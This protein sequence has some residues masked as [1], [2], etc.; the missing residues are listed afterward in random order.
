[1]TRFTG[2]LRIACSVAMAQLLL[3]ACSSM[4][5]SKKE[6]DGT[7]RKEPELRQMYTLEVRAP[8]AQKS[9]LTSFL[10]LAR[11]Q[12]GPEADRIS[13]E[14][15]DRLVAG[16]PAQARSLV[17]TQGYFNSQ[18]TA[19]REG[20][21]RDGLPLVIVELT[22]GPRTTVESVELETSGHLEKAASARDAK[23]IELTAEVRAKWPL[24]SGEAFTQSEWDGAKNAALGVLRTDGYPAASWA[25]TSARIDADSN[26]ARLYG[27]ADS[28]PLF[29][30]GDVL[31]TGLE[32]YDP[33]AVRNL[34][35]F[36]GG[37]R[38]SEKAMLDTQDRLQRSGLFEGAVV[39]I[40][41]D[42]S[43][44][45]AVP[46]TVKVREAPLQQATVGIGFAD[47]TGERVTLEHTHRRVFG[48]KFFGTN[49]VAKNKLDLGR[50]QQSWQGDFSSHPLEGGWRNILGA[51][52]RRETAK[53]TTVSSQRL[54][55][56]RAVETERIDRLVYL[57]LQQAKTTSSALTESNRALS[58]NYNWI[59][60]DIDNNLLPTLGWA[61]NLESAVGYSW[62]DTSDSGAFG[63]LKAR[64]T[65]FRPLGSTWFGNVRLEI[66]QVF[67]NSAVGIPDTLLFRAGGD[68]SVRGYAY[69]S[70]GP[71]LTGVV[72]SG[73][74]LMTASGEVARPIS[75]DFPALWWALFADA[76][77]A[78]DDWGGIKPVFG[79]GTG[80]RW[81]SPVGPLR[82]DLAYGEELRKFRLH[83]SVGVA[84]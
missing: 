75:S 52:L 55:V 82:V 50:D 28:G 66:G 79:Y 61:A 34:T 40:A 77:N 21:D 65:G 20:I 11:F 29:S 81:R 51:G 37:Q 1:M 72:S 15:I 25:N 46:V 44:A 42:P 7:V 70:L 57:E 6:T 58:G 48:R 45:D 36:R 27:L 22:P 38:Y 8:S 18:A 64:V 54:R 13:V 39:S 76:G 68:D 67:A 80:I 83:L 4:P 60:R 41:A 59:W 63:R 10:D 31:I 69:R 53:G 71:L 84:F 17:E 47:V 32:R 62:S 5:W 30:F 78:A 2:F 74:V 3:S 23:A 56:G 35:T 73:R 43:L 12:R 19:R 14:E 33:S 16:A 9:L 26:R 49:W 24:K